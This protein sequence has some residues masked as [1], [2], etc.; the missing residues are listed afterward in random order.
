MKYLVLIAIA[1]LCG[2]AD[3]RGSL[4]PIGSPPHGQHVGDTLNAIGF[5]IVSIGAIGLAASVL[6]VIAS[7]ISFLGISLAPQVRTWI[8]EA[9]ILCFAAILVGSTFMWVGDHPWMVLVA[10]G[11]VALGLVVRYRSLVLA[12]FN[13]GVP[14]PAPT[15]TPI[16]KV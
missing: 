6:A 7:A 15:V 16:M 8:I 12:L 2:C 11:L 3:S 10:C 13:L 9:A 14:Q 1:V 5:W 4:P